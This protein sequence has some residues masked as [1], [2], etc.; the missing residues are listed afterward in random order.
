MF[1]SRGG[2]GGG[3][4]ERGLFKATLLLVICLVAWVSDSPR[5]HCE[6]VNLPANLSSLDPLSHSAPRWAVG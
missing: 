3:E 6:L 5:L 2:E 4:G 1:L